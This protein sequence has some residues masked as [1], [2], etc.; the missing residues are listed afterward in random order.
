MK[1]FLPLTQSLVI[2]EQMSEILSGSF[3][4]PKGLWHNK[5]PNR[6]VGVGGVFIY[7]LSL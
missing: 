1:E 6:Q 5:M 7:L 4:G 3:L 2:I